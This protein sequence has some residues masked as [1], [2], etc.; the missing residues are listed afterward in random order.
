MPNLHRQRG[1]SLFELMIVVAVVGILSAVAV[2]AY[3]SY[4]AT[5][6][7]AKVTANFEEAVRLG[8]NTFNLEKARVALGLVTSVPDTTEDWI[9]LFNKSGAQAPGGGPAFIPSSDSAGERGD[10]ATGAIGVRWSPAV[11]ETVSKGK[12]DKNQKCKGGNLDKKGCVIPASDPKLEL[13]RPLYSDLDGQH[14]TIA[15][16]VMQM[17]KFTN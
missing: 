8:N 7:M 14:V 6:N 5:A 16:D 10:S 11:A 1:F 2:P 4:I 17:E 13:W 15:D 9:L 12:N 3:R